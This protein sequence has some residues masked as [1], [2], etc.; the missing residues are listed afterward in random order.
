MLAS[1]PIKKCVNCAQWLKGAGRATAP[2]SCL[3]VDAPWSGYR[4]EAT[5]LCQLNQGRAFDLTKYLSPPQ[6]FPGQIVVTPVGALAQ[7]SAQVIGH[8]DASVALD[9]LFADE[10]GNQIQCKH[11]RAYAGP[12]VVF[13][14][15]G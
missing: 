4:T 12:N 14:K 13:P 5:N 9:Y 7:I 8:G 10:Q 15:H 11:L 1:L 3:H 2:G 6:C